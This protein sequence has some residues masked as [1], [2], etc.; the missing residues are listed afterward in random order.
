MQNL[1]QTRKTLLVGCFVAFLLAMGGLFFYLVSLPQPPSK[2]SR[3]EYWSNPAARSLQK[4]GTHPQAKDIDG[5]A[6]K[7][8][9][10][11]P[12]ASSAEVRFSIQASGSEPMQ[13][14]AAF[15]E[16][17]ALNLG[18]SL[19]IPQKLDDEFYKY[20]EEFQTGQH[21]R[22][23]VKEND[24]FIGFVDVL[25]DCEISTCKVVLDAQFSDRGWIIF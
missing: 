14:I 7:S 17:N 4:L 23:D 15:F 10:V 6:D 12:S 13:T 18:W 2:F 5:R 25:I 19:V 8:D 21:R 9:F 1:S 16:K 11:T 20:D 22:F 24:S 3:W